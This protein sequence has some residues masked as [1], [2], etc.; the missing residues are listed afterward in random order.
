MNDRLS[1]CYIVCIANITRAEVIFVVDVG[2]DFEKAALPNIKDLIKSTL[3]V[4]ELE[5]DKIRVS[6]LNNVTHFT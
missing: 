1:L 3:I 6:H 5:E 2:K 4:M